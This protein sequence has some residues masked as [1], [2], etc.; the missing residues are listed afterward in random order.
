[1]STRSWSPGLGDFEEWVLQGSR[2]KVGIGVILGLN[3]PYDLIFW[4][5][6]DFGRAI[7]YIIVMRC[8]ICQKEFVPS[9]YR[10]NQQVCS[11]SGCQNLRQV[12]N[13]QD[14]RLRN[15]D[16]FKSVG[17]SKVWKETRHQYNKL[18]RQEHKK[19]LKKYAWEHAEERRNYM[20][21]YMRKHRHQEIVSEEKS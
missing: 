14:W 20:R 3:L 16:Y 6:V 8:R 10:P 12:Q 21:E 1:M 11:Q 2:L 17:Q 15:P 9:K 5:K 18:W 13:E 7:C 4:V 19:Q